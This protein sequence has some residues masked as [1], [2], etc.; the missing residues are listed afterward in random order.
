MLAARAGEGK[1]EELLFNGDRVAVGKK[2]EK[3]SGVV[4]W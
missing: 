2:I 1:D 4:W 3:N